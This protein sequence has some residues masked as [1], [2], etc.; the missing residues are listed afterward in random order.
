M[1]LPVHIADEQSWKPGLSIE[2]T[3]IRDEAFS[4]YRGNEAKAS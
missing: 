4:T 2:T 1:V 3:C